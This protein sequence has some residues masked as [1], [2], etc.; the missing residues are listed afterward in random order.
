[1]SRTPGTVAAGHDAEAV[2]LVGSGGRLVLIEI[3][4][5]TASNRS[6]LADNKGGRPDV[7]LANE[8]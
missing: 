5:P 7:R 3:N 1:M 6:T 4:A 8:D 2:M